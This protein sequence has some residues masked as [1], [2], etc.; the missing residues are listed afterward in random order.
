MYHS[1]EE[2]TQ[3]R[4]LKPLK[5]KAWYKYQERR[6]KSIGKEG[7]PNEEGGHLG[8]EEPSEGRQGVEEKRT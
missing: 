1:A 7:L 8:Q 6:D 5:L 3:A 4:N 2:M